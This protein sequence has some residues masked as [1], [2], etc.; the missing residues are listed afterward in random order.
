MSA[1]SLYTHRISFGSTVNGPGT[2]AVVWTQGC[3]IGCAGCFNP[4][5]H[6][7][8]AGGAERHDPVELGRRLARLTVDGLTISGGE[9]LDQP[10]AV[11]ALAEAYRAACPGTV[12]LFSGYTV[13]RITDDPGKR[14]AVLAGDA[15]LA[16]PYVPGDL[17][18]AKELIDISGR[19]PPDRLVPTRMWEA[20][21]TGEGD[22][23][24]SG[25]PGPGH[26]SKMSRLLQL[27]HRNPSLPD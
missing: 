17:W 11:R 27:T 12:L 1:V 15:V 24:L 8:E 5:T 7:P 6:E 22:V 9:P 10:A 4:L 3:S 14:A 20:S 16:G 19:I 26:K 21:V 18:A 2:R 25:Y 23:V 13:K